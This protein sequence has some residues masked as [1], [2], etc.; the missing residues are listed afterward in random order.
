M[1]L[2]SR[3]RQIC[4]IN[5]FSKFIRLKEKRSEKMENNELFIQDVLTSTYIDN[6]YRNELNKCYEN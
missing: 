5:A 4:K 2:N 6:N 1:T 3:R